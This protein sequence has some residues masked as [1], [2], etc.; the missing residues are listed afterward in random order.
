L[1]GFRVIGVDRSQALIE[2]ARG[3]TQTARFVVGDVL[4]WRPSQAADAVV[5]R[6]VLND[7][8]ADVERRGRI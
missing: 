3:K 8:T 2:Q 6:G 7:L 1:R 5:C 4:E